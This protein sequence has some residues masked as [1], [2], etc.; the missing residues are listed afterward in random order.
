MKYSIWKSPSLYTWS[1]V[2]I[3]CL[4][5]SDLTVGLLEQPSFIIHKIGA[6]IIIWRSQNLKNS[7]DLVGCFPPQLST[8]VDNT[9]LDLQNS[10]YP[11]Q[12]HSTIIVYGNSS[13]IK[14]TIDFR[15]NFVH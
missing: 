13:E 2:F 14:V 3:C 5:F 12:P 11:S 6:S 7:A 8:S 4:G 15:S 10:S 9:L 1:E